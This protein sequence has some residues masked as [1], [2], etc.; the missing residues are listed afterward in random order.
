M[1]LKMLGIMIVIS[2]V[3][4]TALVYLPKYFPKFKK[5]AQSPPKGLDVLVKE[6]QDISYQKTII[7]DELDK[8]ERKISK[9]KNNLNN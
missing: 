7:E 3:V 4:Y 2:I 8:S 6:S 1:I 9:V 5:K